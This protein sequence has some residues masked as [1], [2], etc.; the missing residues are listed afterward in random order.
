MTAVAHGDV[1]LDRDGVLVAERPGY[2]LSPDEVDLL[3]GAADAVARLTVAQRRVF[4]ITNQSPVG[5]GLLSPSDLDAIHRRLSELIAAEGGR[6]CGY[7]VCPHT[8]IDRCRCRK[9]QPGLLFEAR[10]VAGVD[11]DR[12]TLVGDQLTDV[13]AARDAG[14]NAIL[15]SPPGA[16]ATTPPA[17]IAVA[18]DLGA[19]V[20]AVRFE[21]EG[22]QSWFGRSLHR[23]L[24]VAR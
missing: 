5:R 2:V 18:T 23:D 11:L 4:V 12:A 19:S 24:V 6:I 20:H 17:G 7:F 3:P 1:L 9:P 8:P 13:E 10:D 21:R 22:V 15:L 16:G 14:C